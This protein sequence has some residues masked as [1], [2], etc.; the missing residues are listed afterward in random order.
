[1]LRHFP[2]F[3]PFSERSPEL[4]LAH[5]RLDEVD[6]GKDRPSRSNPHRG[7][8]S[9]SEADAAAPQSWDDR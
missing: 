7:V 9:G 4:A 2:S 5:G 3:I 1:M 6:L 8:R